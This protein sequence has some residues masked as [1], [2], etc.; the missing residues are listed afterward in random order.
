MQ[1]ATLESGNQIPL[2]RTLGIRLTEIAERHA[3]MEVDVT[4]A[5]RNYFGGA[6]GGL[7][8]TLV[9]TV[10]FF[11]APLLPSGRSATTT[12]LTVSYVRGAS[13]GDHLAARS[14]LLHLG[15]RTASLAVR[16]TDGA[17]RLVAHGAATLMVLDEPDAPTSA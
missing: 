16:V 5:H 14:E 9:D 8:A 15:R 13:V 2:L 10:C 1:P 3:T 7:I 17:G 12:N 11:P 6:H 4:D